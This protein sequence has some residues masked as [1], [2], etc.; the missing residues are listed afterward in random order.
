VNISDAVNAF[1][2]EAAG[3]LGCD[4]PNLKAQVTLQSCV[5]LA[6]QPWPHF[7]GCRIQTAVVLL[8]SSWDHHAQFTMHWLGQ[9]CAST[10]LAARF[11]KKP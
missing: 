10:R 5:V 4:E 8:V 7:A 6:L 2:Q 1:L 11:A 9:V 3:S